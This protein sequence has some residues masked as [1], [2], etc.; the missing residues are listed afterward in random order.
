MAFHLCSIECFDGSDGRDGTVDD[1]SCDPGLFT[2]TC[3]KRAGEALGEALDEHKE[4]DGG[5]D[6][7]CECP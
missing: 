6:D 5:E 2:F 1:G 3:K 4:R 7:R